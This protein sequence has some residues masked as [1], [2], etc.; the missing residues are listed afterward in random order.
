M[1]LL[2]H[3]YYVELCYIKTKYGNVFYFG[4]IAPKTPKTPDLALS[5]LFSTYTQ[6]PWN[7]NAC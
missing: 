3:C 6:N 2:N 7:P 5:R 1:F 4:H